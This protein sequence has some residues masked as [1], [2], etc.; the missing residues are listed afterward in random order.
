MEEDGGDAVRVWS[1]EAGCELC[2]RGEAGEHK[3]LLS[4]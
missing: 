3:R 2:G 4:S 1:F